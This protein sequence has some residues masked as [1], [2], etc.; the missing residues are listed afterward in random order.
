MPSFDNKNTFS[1]YNK[2]VVIINLC[3]VVYK[4]Y[5]INI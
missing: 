2:I 5:G 4:I 3:I 1:I